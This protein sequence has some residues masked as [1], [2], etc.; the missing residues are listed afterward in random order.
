VK[1]LYIDDDESVCDIIMRMAKE[2]RPDLEILTTSII[3]EVFGI[4]KDNLDIKTVIMDGSMADHPK[5]IAEIKKVLP[6]D[7]QFIGVSCNS[8]LLKKLDK[9]GCDKVHDEKRTV[10]RLVG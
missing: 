2:G 9:A 7:T 4:V 3:G 10:L 8:D 5:L 6:E 1:V